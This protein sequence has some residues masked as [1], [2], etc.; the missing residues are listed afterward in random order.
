MKKPHLA[1]L[2]CPG[3]IGG[4]TN[5]GRLLILIPTWWVA[6]SSSA[7][8]FNGSVKVPSAKVLR[9][10]MDTKR[11]DQFCLEEMDFIQQFYS[12]KKKMKMKIKKK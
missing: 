7:L 5:S 2:Y 1:F 10:G 3:I 4:K 11:K 9:I 12:D 6:Y 8:W